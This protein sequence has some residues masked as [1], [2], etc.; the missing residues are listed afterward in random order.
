MPLEDVALCSSAALQ[1]LW[2]CSGRASLL[3][4]VGNIFKCADRERTRLGL[5]GFPTL[6]AAAQQAHFCI[7]NHRF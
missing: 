6:T 3:W 7:S 4:Y 2:S 1:Y 5:Q